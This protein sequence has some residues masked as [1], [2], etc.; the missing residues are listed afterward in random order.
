VVVYFTARIDPCVAE[1][2]KLKGGE[3]A[4]LTASDH[5]RATVSDFCASS[6]QD[7]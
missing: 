4:Q 1:A 7:G 2:S 6:S 3:D 5:Y